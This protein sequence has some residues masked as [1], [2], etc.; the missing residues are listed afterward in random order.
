MAGGRTTM[1]EQLDDLAVAAASLLATGALQGVGDEAARAA[2]HRIREFIRNKFGKNKRLRFALARIDECG[3]GDPALATFAH[4][5]ARQLAQ[6]PPELQQ[7]LKVL[8]EEAQRD[9]TLAA[10]V[11][12]DRARINK[13]VYISEVHGDV[14]F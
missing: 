8:V 4:E 3:D 14:S 7:Q 11:A 10:I 1:L 6:A 13:A 2:A 5:L 12:K 9:S